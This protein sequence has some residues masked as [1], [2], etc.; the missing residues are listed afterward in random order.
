[1]EQIPFVGRIKTEIMYLVSIY[2]EYGICI[3]IY[4]LVVHKMAT[5]FFKPN[6]LVKT[7][8]MWNRSMFLVI[9]KIGLGVV[10]LKV[11]L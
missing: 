8:P 3:M 9:F 5:G 4:G 10:Y 2:E 6:D 11:K 1:M 7:M